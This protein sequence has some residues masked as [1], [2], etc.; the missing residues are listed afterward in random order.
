MLGLPCLLSY[1][2]GERALTRLEP[3]EIFGQGE[4]RSIPPP[5]FIAQVEML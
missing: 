1:R 4:E 3:I 2:H 5:S